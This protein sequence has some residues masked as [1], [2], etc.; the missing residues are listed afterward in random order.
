MDSINFMYIFYLIFFFGLDLPPPPCSQDE[1]ALVFWI[2]PVF[3][4]IASLFFLSDMI[5]DSLTT[6]LL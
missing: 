6:D 1:P 5:R 4:F 2:N 3:S